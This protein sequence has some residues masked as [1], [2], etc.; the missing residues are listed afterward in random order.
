M[1]EILLNDQIVA[2]CIEQLT[3]LF[4]DTIVRNVGVEMKVEVRKHLAPGPA[5]TPAPAVEPK[6]AAKK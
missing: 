5:S 6:A 4:V 2:V 1:Y 3:K